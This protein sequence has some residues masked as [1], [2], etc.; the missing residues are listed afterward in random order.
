MSF[1]GPACH[2]RTSKDSA[3]INTATFPSARRPVYTTDVWIRRE[4]A[5]LPLSLHVLPGALF[6]FVDMIIH[7]DRR[8]VVAERG[9]ARR[10]KTTK[11]GAHPETCDLLMLPK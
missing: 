9:T 11:H 4:L 10:L 7:A 3:K 2:V 6:D 1:V 5:L 8:Q